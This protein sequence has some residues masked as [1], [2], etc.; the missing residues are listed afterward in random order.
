MRPPIRILTVLAW[1]VAW[2]ALPA[3]PAV[4]ADQTQNGLVGQPAPPLD[5]RAHLGPRPPSIAQLQGRVVALFFW[6]HWCSECKA[7]SPMLARVLEKYRSQ[8]LVLIAPTQRYGYVTEGRAAPPDRELRYIVQVRDRYYPFLKREPVP[9]SEANP[10]RYRVDGV[11]RIVLIDRRGIIRVDHPGR[12][13]EEELE[14]AIRR[15]L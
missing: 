5:T 11:P 8:G 4:P 7:M 10:E 9:T 2:V 12:M 6:A 15:L 14:T 1:L 3:S 13:T